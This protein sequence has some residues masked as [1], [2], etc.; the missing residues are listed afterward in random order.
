MVVNSARV[1]TG[2][3]VQKS[4]VQVVPILIKF[5]LSQ[6]LVNIQKSWNVSLNETLSGYVYLKYPCVSS[7]YCTTIKPMVK[8]KNLRYNFA[9]NGTETDK[10]I[11]MTDGRD[12]GKNETK[13]IK[14]EVATSKYRERRTHERLKLLEEACVKSNN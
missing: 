1:A 3:C 2:K 14:C 13:E 11:Q 7:L 9:I 5:T 12:Q 10:V 6:P 4:D 8:Q